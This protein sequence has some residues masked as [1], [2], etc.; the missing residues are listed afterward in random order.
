MVIQQ[1]GGVTQTVV[2]HPGPLPGT[3]Q[4]TKTTTT[5]QPPIEQHVVI[6]KVIEQQAPTPVPKTMTI[7]V[8][9]VR[10]VNGEYTEYDVKV[11][12]DL[13][14]HGIEGYPILVSKR[15][16][17]FLELYT[18]IV[19]ILGS[20]ARFLPEFPAKVW[21]GKLDPAVIDQRKEGFQHLMTFIQKEPKLRT[22]NTI[23]HFFGITHTRHAITAKDKDTN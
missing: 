4:I 9:D 6:T 1:P 19:E 5:P 8:E 17:D 3:V 22:C 23:D 2:Q 20:D 10:T 14:Q 7:T 15:Y 16:N 18:T 12:S 11:V 21:F 13:P